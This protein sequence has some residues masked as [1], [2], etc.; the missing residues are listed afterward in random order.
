[1]IYEIEFDGQ[2]LA[3]V[4]IDDSDAAK[5]AI[6]EMAEFWAGW[7]ERLAAANG[8]HTKCWLAQLGKRILRYGCAPKDEEGW[9]PLD[10]SHGIRVLGEWPYEFDESLIEITQEAR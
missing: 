4:S 2:L 3:R 6:K 5:S 1:M 10:G 9:Y 7:R 8:D